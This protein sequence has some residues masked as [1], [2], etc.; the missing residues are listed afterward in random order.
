M[1]GSAR[2]R[3]N[4]ASNSSEKSWNKQKDDRKGRH[5]ILDWSPFLLKINPKYQVLPNQ[6]TYFIFSQLPSTWKWT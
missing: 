1:W 6:T 2:N 3:L 4:S 5:I